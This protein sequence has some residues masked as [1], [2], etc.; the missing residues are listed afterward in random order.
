MQEN[1]VPHGRGKVYSSP[2]QVNLGQTSAPQQIGTSLNSSGALVAAMKAL[3]AEIKRLEGQLEMSNS[4]AASLEETL[5]NQTTEWRARLE[6]QAR[7]I[8]FHESQAE[9]RMQAWLEEEG[10]LQTFV[11]SL[12]TEAAEAKASLVEARRHSETKYE[13]LQSALS[14]SQKDNSEI[15]KILTEKVHHVSIEKERA[16]F[17]YQ[18]EIDHLNQ[19][20]DNL[21]TNL[22]LA[23]DKGD[24]LKS[25]HEVKIKEIKKN[26]E[27]KVKALEDKNHSLQDELINLTEKSKCSLESI[28]SKLNKESNRALENQKKLEQ[29]LHLW[30]EEA[31]SKDSDLKKVMEYLQDEKENSHKY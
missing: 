27:R 6:E 25:E 13:H 17:E 28:T 10:R 12:Q 11:Q 19:A 26:F 7:F 3:Q 1:G 24:Q 29:E 21:K 4:R 5:A 20:L 9:D 30:R 16:A 22:S 14:Q 2:R 8:Q 31:I 15:E 23:I 18:R